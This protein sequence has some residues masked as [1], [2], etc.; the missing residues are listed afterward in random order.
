MTHSPYQPERL[1]ARVGGE[2]WAVAIAT[3]LL[4]FILLGILPR[5]LW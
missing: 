3:A 4:A 1:L 5:I 2:E